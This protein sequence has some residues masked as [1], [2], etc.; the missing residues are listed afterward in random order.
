MPPCSP[1]QNI[2]LGQPW[3]MVAVDIL[4][5]PLSTNNNRYLLVLQDYYTKWADAVPLPDQMAVHIVTAQINFFCTYGPPQILHSDQGQNFE[6]TILTQVLQ[7]FGIRKSRTTPYHPQ[8]D[9]MV[10][11]FNR[12]LLQLQRAYV[13]S[14][15]D[16]ETYLPQV[17]Y[18]YRTECHS[19]TGVSP[20][21][22]L[23]GRD[24]PAL[25]RISQLAYDSISYPA[26][27]QAKL[28]ELQDFV[29]ANI[30]QAAPNPKAVYDQHTS[31][32]SFK[33]YGYQYPQLASW[34]L[35]GRGMGC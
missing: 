4:Q 20:Y 3:Q 22:L 18:A 7:A 31:A 16:W 15:S 32:A 6:S 21:L 27:I 9:G 10:E 25:Q 33:L 1:F 12:T 34:S 17:L 14:Q 11:H 23:Y 29:H 35:N 5:V 8:G 2:P 26:V 30:A 19:S 28:A 13:A 24:P